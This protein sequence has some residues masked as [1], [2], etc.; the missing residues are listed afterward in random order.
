MVQD[1]EYNL[2]LPT[3]E[4][5]HS[6]SSSSQSEESYVASPKTGDTNSQTRGFSQNSM[7]EASHMSLPRGR[8]P[9]NTQSSL[10]A[11]YF[12]YHVELS[13]LAHDA[14]SQ[15]YSPAIRQYRW[16]KI[17]ALID[18]YD[19]HLTTWKMNLEPPFRD[20]TNDLASNLGQS[21][22]GVA[23]EIQF[24]CVRAIINRPCLYR[25]ERTAFR[26]SSHVAVSR[27]IS[28]ARAV[29]DLVYTSP[30]A[31]LI[32]HGPK[33]WL[34]LHH[35][36]RALT[37]VLL[38]LAFR[39]EHMPSEAEELLADAKKAL[40][41][42]QKMAQT[43]KIAEHTWLTMSSLHVEAARRVGVDAGEG[44]SLGNHTELPNG[45]LQHSDEDATDSLQH[46]MPAADLHQSQW[47]P[48]MPFGAAT[49]SM[50]FGNFLP[51]NMDQVRPNQ[52][53]L[54][55]LNFVE[56]DAFDQFSFE[57]MTMGRGDVHGF[58]DPYQPEFVGGPMHHPHSS[59]AIPHGSYS[60]GVP[61]LQSHQQQHKG[62]GVRADG[63]LTDD[64]FGFDP[65]RSS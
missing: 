49:D 1:R 25:R 56:P 18:D 42:L 52:D 51:R 29:I 13:G 43:S 2:T 54:A 45:W 60:V 23:L 15:L 5:A 6:A 28:S 62:S 11:T 39:A 10:E 12:K 61:Q 64:C 22:L 46:P 21:P 19:D 35:T 9:N 65:S 34:L 36:K 57:P 26:Q 14:V 58:Y 17:Q 20:L 55:Y 40:A 33:W 27:C 31:A 50:S 63:Y 7:S 4:N 32:D 3:P 16:S 37:V 41:W 48:P 24:H 30:A 8:M 38:E 53:P 44:A 47:R 59:F